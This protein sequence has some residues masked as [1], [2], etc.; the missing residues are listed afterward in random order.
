MDNEKLL[1]TGDR[2]IYDEPAACTAW[3]PIHMD[4]AA[5]VAEMEKGDF[6]KAYKILE[7][8]MPFARLLGMICDHPCESVCVREAVGGAIR[9]SELEKAAVKHGYSPPKKALH[10]P[11]NASKVAVIGGGLSG[12]STALELSRKGFKVTVY[13]K[14]EKLGGRLWDY[15]SSNLDKAVI[16]EELQIVSK[17]NIDV[18]LN[19][20]ISPID[21]NEILNEN[22]AVFLGTGEWDETLQINAETFQVQC[23]S[24]FAGG[25]LLYKNGSII[26]SVSSGKRAAVSIERYVKG[27]SLTAVRER[28]GPF[29]TPLKYEVDNIEPAAPVVRTTDVYSEDEAVN[30]AGRCFKCRCTKCIDSC[31]HMKKF[32]I[33]P[34]EY[35]RQIIHNEDTFMGTRY[36]NKMINSCTMCGLCAERCHLDISMK[37]VI[38][39][40]RESMVEKGK[41][42][43][44]AHDFAL[45]DMEFS[46]SSQFFMLKSPPPI[47]EDQIESRKKELFTYPRIT[48]S[49]YAQS[50]FKGDSPGKEKVDYLFYPGCQ[51][52]ASSPEYVEKAYQYLLAKIKEGV[53]IMLGCCG[54]PADW[55]GR[56]D[57]MEGSIERLRDAWDKM[58]KPT[59]I[60]ACSSCCGIFEKY[61]SDI[62]YVSLWEI[63]ERYGLPETAQIGKNH[64]LNVHDACATRHNKNIHEALRNITLKLGYEIQELNYSKEKTKCCGYG[65]L[66]YFANREQTNDFVE[67]R[68]KESDKD[69]LVYCAMCKDLFVEGGKRTYHILDLIFGE[70]LAELAHKKMPNLSQRHANR[71]GLKNKLLRELWNE[72]PEKEL[73]K[74]NELNLVIPPEIWKIMEERYILFEDIEKVIEHSSRSGERFFNSEDSSY[75]ANLRLKNLTYWVRYAEKADGIHIISVYSHRM[76]VVK[77]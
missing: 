37:D 54:A 58:G 59:F 60:L 16:E 51:L 32:K 70:N 31:S 29:A 9:I 33:S 64:I 56:Q 61:L 28:E 13:E 46:N 21:L 74:R 6:H 10:I 1:K 53:G 44:S 77:E 2:C 15:E 8:R 47:P 39:E 19:R 42:P 66:V 3:C 4:V 34:K 45:K 62:P 26:L 18:I 49:N 25:R 57:L 71:A 72:E 43:P 38:Q 41:M 40:T 65:G 50:I 23:S 14:T 67:D 22:N 73:T 27:I 69:F 30:E 20:H 35:T 36:A 76:E 7:K 11:K 24:L 55:A 68:I 5:F 75:L 17:L 52:S 48:F 63:F 12:I